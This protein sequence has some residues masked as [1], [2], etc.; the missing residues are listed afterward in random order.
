MYLKT[1]TNLIA[2]RSSNLVFKIY[3]QINYLPYKQFKVIDDF[4]I[5]LNKT[6]LSAEIELVNDNLFTINFYTTKKQKKIS[7]LNFYQIK[8]SIDEITVKYDRMHNKVIFLSKLFKKPIV[9]DRLEPHRWTSMIQWIQLNYLNNSF[10]LNEY[11]KLIV[12]LGDDQK[13][14]FPN[15]IGKINLHNG[16]I[17]NPNLGLLVLKQMGL[18]NIDLGQLIL[19]NKTVDCIPKGWLS[20]IKLTKLWCLKNERD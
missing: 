2:L 13:V 16:I 1:N 6:R 8:N 7:I 18:K 12:L 4:W 11:L 10:I 5:Y 9:M 3:N 17:K 19:K 20:K 14:I 15:Y